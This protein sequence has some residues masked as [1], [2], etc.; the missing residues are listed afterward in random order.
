MFLLISVSSWTFHLRLGLPMSHRSFGWY[1]RGDLGSEL[2]S[3]VA[4]HLNCYSGGFLYYYCVYFKS[5]YDVTVSLA[6]Q[7]S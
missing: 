3:F 7:H 6:V 4:G 2:V 5:V 1:W